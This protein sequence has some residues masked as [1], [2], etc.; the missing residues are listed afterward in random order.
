MNST[1]RDFLIDQMVDLC[2]IPDKASP[3]SQWAEILPENRKKQE[4]YTEWIAQPI[5]H[6]PQHL[7]EL[8][9]TVALIQTKNCSQNNAQRNLLHDLPHEKGSPNG[10]RFHDLVS[11]VLNELP[12]GAHLRSM[13]GGQQQLTNSP[14]AIT[15]Q[16]DH[17]FCSQ[18]R[19][20]YRVQ[21]AR[22]IEQIGIVVRQDKP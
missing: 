18:N 7:L 15:T 13:K 5:E 19:L 6:L 8:L 4:T 17:R 22:G 12:V 20:E 14:M 3:G 1:L 9:A 2:S 21:F 11:N 10:S 16:P